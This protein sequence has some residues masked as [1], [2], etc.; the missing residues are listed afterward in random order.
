MGNI[1]C[2]GKSFVLILYCLTDA[3]KQ[4]GVIND[5]LTV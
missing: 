3:I 5:P 4:S 1:L 2:T